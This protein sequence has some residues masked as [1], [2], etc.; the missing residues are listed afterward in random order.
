MVG[1]PSNM[2]SR[3][4]SLPAENPAR[5]DSR[6]LYWHVEHQRLLVRIRSNDDNSITF[7][8]SRWALYSNGC[9]G[10]L[11]G[12]RIKLAGRTAICDDGCPAAGLF[13]SLLRFPRDLAFIG[14][15]FHSLCNAR[16]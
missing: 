7:Q 4:S 14:F 10:A 13:F 8:P 5:A 15:E 16:N 2:G 11:I 9:T 6:Q 1:E 12:A 3:A